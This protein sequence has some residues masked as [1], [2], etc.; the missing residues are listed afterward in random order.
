MCVAATMASCSLP[1]KDRMRVVLGGFP[2]TPASPREWATRDTRQGKVQ[3][4]T[5][6]TS[7]AIR[8]STRFLLTTVT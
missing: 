2:L 6:D 4:G 5:V 3:V 7:Q 1:G 8:S